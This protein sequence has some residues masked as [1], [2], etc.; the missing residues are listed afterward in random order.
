MISE[1]GGKVELKRE[2][3]SILFQGE[4]ISGVAHRSSDLD[5][6]SDEIDYAPIIFGNAAPQRLCEML[7]RERRAIFLYP[8]RE[9]KQSISLWSLSLS[10]NR[11]PGDFGVEHYST[12]VLPDWLHTVRQFKGNST[13]IKDMENNNLSP[14][15]LADYSSLDTDLDEKGPYLC[16][17]TGVDHIE[18]WAY[19]SPDE[20]AA[21]KNLW[22]ELII[23]DLDK[24]FPGF[25]KAIKTKELATAETM[26]HYLNTS[27]GAVY[28]FAPEGT[29]FDHFQRK[30]ETSA[31]GLFLASA[32]CIGGG[33]SGAM[34]GGALA[35]NAAMKWQSIMV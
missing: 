18:N 35:A 12:F 2:A 19:L 17:V 4:R 31:V 11:R 7:P 27:G 25:S 24:M 13:L 10:L 20:K 3:T 34:L 8:Y 16:S 23:A 30:P 9:R 14:Y 22:T 1:A 5:L 15:V 26:Q 28:G 29:L 32:Y 33:Y 6:K 21:R